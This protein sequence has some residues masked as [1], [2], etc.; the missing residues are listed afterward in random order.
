MKCTSVVVSGV[1]RTQHIVISRLGLITGKGC[2]A[3]GKVP[4][5]K[6]VGS[7]AQVSF[8]SGAPQEAP[9]LSSSDL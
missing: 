9:R 5:V 4:A 1:P 3:K 2:R 7:E 8:P 6:L